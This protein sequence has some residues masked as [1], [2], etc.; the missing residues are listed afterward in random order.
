MKFHVLASLI[1]LLI[2]F[3]S[4]FDSVKMA[5]RSYKKAQQ[6]IS[7]GDISKAK[8][9]L[10]RSFTGDFI[11]YDN[12]DLYSG[13]VLE[14]NRTLFNDSQ[15][16]NEDELLVLI[17]LCKKASDTTRVKK[18]AVDLIVD[19]KRNDELTS[20]SFNDIYTVY[21]K[22][23]SDSAHWNHAHVLYDLL[24]NPQLINV[25]NSR[26]LTSFSEGVYSVID[27]NLSVP[28]LSYTVQQQL[29]NMMVEKVKTQYSKDYF[30]TKRFEEIRSGF[31]TY[32][33]E[34]KKLESELRKA[35]TSVNIA[36]YNKPIL[37]KEF[38]YNIIL[39]EFETFLTAHVDSLPSIDRDVQKAL[40]G[41]DIMSAFISAY[42]TRRLYDNY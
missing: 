11:G 23:Y 12:F 41:P 26:D 4:C 42:N 32:Y 38:L 37:E 24:R 34:L 36:S 7:S 5:E 35:G 33:Q 17:Q 21:Q 19:A 27:S 25:V 40:D 28:K 6:A 3:T 30:G 14:E 10:Y 8:D 20:E 16:V 13:I 39:N 22:L 15:R 18:N 31:P 1:T 29:M 9:I 2:L